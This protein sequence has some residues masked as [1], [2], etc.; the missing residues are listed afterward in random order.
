VA[1][2]REF[3]PM[4]IAGMPEVKGDTFPGFRLNG[5]EWRIYHR[6]LSR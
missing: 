1:N 4:K 2:A 6:A 3:K 5:F